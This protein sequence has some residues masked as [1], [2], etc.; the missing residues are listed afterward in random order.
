MAK[1]YHP[2]INKAPDAKEKFAELNGAYQILVDDKKREMYDMTGSTDAAEGGNAGYGGPFGG[3]MS[4]EQAEEIFNQFFGGG[5][6]FGG[7]YSSAFGKDPFGGGARESPDAPRHGSDV[8]QVLNV[9]L[10]EAVY[11]AKKDIRV[12]KA[13]SCTGCSGTGENPKKKSTT[14]SACNGKG[15]VEQR[16]AFFVVRTTCGKC[17]GSGKTTHSCPTCGGSGY[18]KEMKTLEVTVNA[19][20]DNGSLLRVKGYGEPGYR[21]GTPGDVYLEIVVG[22]DPIFRRK[23]QDLEM[24]VTIPM[25]QAVLGG[26]AHI[27]HLNGENLTVTIPPGSQYNDRVVVNGKGVPHKAA[28]KNGN[29]NVFIKIQI[30]R[31]LTSSQKKAMEEF[32]RT[33]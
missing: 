11:G 27:T 31:N 23:G 19:G 20:V 8:R 17:G 29:L 7:S 24:D 15:E 25:H 12:Q 26:T 22:K 21:G 4:R 3:G 9:S 33:Q 18:Q 6:P 32:A 1:K 13:T 14:C 16:Q 30:P 2:D 28:A 5:G 10:K